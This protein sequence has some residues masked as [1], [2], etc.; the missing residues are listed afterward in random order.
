[1]FSLNLLKFFPVFTLIE[2]QMRQILPLFELFFSA[3]SIRCSPEVLVVHSAVWRH[4]VFCCFFLC[5]T[6]ETHSLLCNTTD[7]NKLGKGDERSRV[8]FVLSA[9]LICKYH[10]PTARA[11]HL[12]FMQVEAFRASI[13]RRGRTGHPSFDVSGDDAKRQKWSETLV[14]IWIFPKK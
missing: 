5:L 3:M 14:S 7:G 8:H 11:L 9:Y 6:L 1:M 13:L 10:M 4:W 2:M 12:S